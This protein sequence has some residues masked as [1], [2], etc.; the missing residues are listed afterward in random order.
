MPNDTGVDIAAALGIELLDQHGKARRIEEF[1]GKQVVV[2]F[3]PMD[4]TPGCTVEGKEFRDLHEQFEAV[5]GVIL[6]VSTDPVE[7]HRAF[8]E[9][10]DFPFTLLADTEGKL[11]TAFGVLKNGLAARTTFVLDHDLHIRR[12]FHDVKPRGHARQVLEFV[13][14]LVESHRMIGG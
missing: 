5:D 12:T 6:G 14:T 3:Y 7:R 9:K 11:A 2:Y 4:D 13:R 10:H 8:A 1:R